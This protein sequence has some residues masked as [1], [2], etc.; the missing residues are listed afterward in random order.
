MKII[1]LENSGNLEMIA[2]EVEKKHI[3]RVLE[4]V[5]A[6]DMNMIEAEKEFINQYLCQYRQVEPNTIGALTS[7]PIIIQ[8]DNVWAYMDYQIY[9]FL[10]ELACGNTVTWIKG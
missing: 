7:A 5:D 9:N 6:G 10:E 1:E 3:R 2:S 4:H 8:D